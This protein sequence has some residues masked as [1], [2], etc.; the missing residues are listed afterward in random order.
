MSE[1][2]WRWAPAFSTNTRTNIMEAI[3]QKRL[4][5]AQEAVEKQ[6]DG[7]R[8]SFHP[9]YDPTAA[10]EEGFAKATRDTE[11]MYNAIVK[12]DVVK[13]GPLR[14]AGRETRFRALG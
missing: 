14:R 2:V 4:K 3:M 13:V 12:D 9:D 11:E 10:G 6:W 8:G 7:G 5:E 1:P